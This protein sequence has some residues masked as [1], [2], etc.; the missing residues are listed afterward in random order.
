MK[1]NVKLFFLSNYFA[2]F[3]ARI[4]DKLMEGKWYIKSCHD[5][6]ARSIQS[7]GGYLHVQYHMKKFYVY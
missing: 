2:Y 7:K 1:K 6:K 5:A 3:C 4:S